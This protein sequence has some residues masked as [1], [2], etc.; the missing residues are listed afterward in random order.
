[1]AREQ[2]QYQEQK[3][4]TAISVGATVLGAMFGRKLS[5]AGIGRATSAARGAGRIGRQREDVSR[6][7]DNVESVM[8]EQQEL[9]RQIEAETA[10]LQA[11][12]DPAAL[13]FEKVEVK[14]RKSDVA[15]L[16][17]TLL[18]LPFEVTREGEYQPLT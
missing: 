11:K 12:F 1:V 16:S 15:T 14:P 18:W 2:S 8:A 9:T 7:Q 5:R 3:M 17:L 4:Q 6:A 10:E 13:A